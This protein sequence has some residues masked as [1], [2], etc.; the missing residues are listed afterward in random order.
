MFPEG[1]ADIRLHKWSLLSIE[2]ALA[3]LGKQKS[4]AQPILDITGGWHKLL[5]QLLGRFRIGDNPS[6]SIKSFERELVSNSMPPILADLNMRSNSWLTR[7]LERLCREGGAILS[8]WDDISEIDRRVAAEVFERF[9]FATRDQD[10]LFPDPVLQRL[11]ERRLQS[12]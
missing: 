11:L 6:D 7:L 1:V 9:G 8:E 12:N 10:L 5:E 4:F 3:E 2:C